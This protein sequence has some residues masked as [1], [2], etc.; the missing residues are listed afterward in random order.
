MRMTRRRRLLC[1]TLLLVPAAARAQGDGP[2]RMRDS[3]VAA[4]QAACSDWRAALSRDG[5]IALLDQRPQSL[6]CVPGDSVLVRLWSSIGPDTASL[7]PLMYLSSEVG[8]AHLLRALL[9]TASDTRRPPHVRLAALAAVVPY[10]RPHDACLGRVLDTVSTFIS[11]CSINHPSYRAASS[12]EPLL[13][14]SIWATLTSLGR[15][16]GSVGR[17]AWSLGP[18][19]GAP[20]RWSE[21]QADRCRRSGKAFALALRANIATF[22]SA[23]FGELAS[24]SE[25]GPPALVLAWR[26]APSDSAVLSRLLRISA[27]VRD[28]RLFQALLQ[29]ARDSARPVAVRVAAVD[30]IAP[31]LHPALHGYRTARG[32]DSCSGWGWYS[33]EAVQE[34]GAVPMGSASRR[35]GVTELRRIAAEEVPLAVRQAA[36]AVARCAETLLDRRAPEMW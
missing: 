26:A 11:T 29:V 35:A 30:G 12:I 34:E 20:E 28:A 2:Q 24:C 21:T 25:S 27:T 1:I 22:L 3:L 14:D 19:W 13:R 16:P 7:I 10:L 6:G 15:E 33:P 18:S 23:E 8:G 31:L 17:A 5:A 9:E 4:R 36:S 32:G